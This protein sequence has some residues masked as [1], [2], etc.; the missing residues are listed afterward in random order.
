MLTRTTP[1]LDP[2]VSADLILTRTAE[3]AEFPH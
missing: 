2:G 3:S 1:L